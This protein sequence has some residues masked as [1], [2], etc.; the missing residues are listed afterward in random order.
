MLQV[1]WDVDLMARIVTTI[2]MVQLAE[3][4][5]QKQVQLVVITEQSD[6]IEELQ[7]EYKLVFLG[8]ISSVQ[9]ERS[10]RLDLQGK[11]IFSVSEYCG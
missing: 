10:N 6:P 11:E 7:E 5:N 4:T 3:I 8:S 2:M 1:K 9:W